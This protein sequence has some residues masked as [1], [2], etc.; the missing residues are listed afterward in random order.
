MAKIDTSDITK[1]LSHI[2][3]WSEGELAEYKLQDTSKAYLHVPIFR[4]CVDRIASSMRQIPVYTNGTR[5]YTMGERAENAWPYPTPL[6]EILY[7]ATVN[8][9]L[10]GAAYIMKVRGER[11]RRVQNLM[12]LNSTTMRVEYAGM[13]ELGN[14]IRRYIQSVNGNT[15]TFENDDIV[16]VRSYHPADDIGPG[17]PPGFTA[18]NPAQTLHYL[19]LFPAKFFEGG[20]VGKTF[21]LMP[22]GTQHK[23]TTRIQTMLNRTITGIK[24]A[25]GVEVFEGRGE[26]DIR[27]LTPAPKDLAMTEVQKIAHQQVLQAFGIPEDVFGQSQANRATAETHHRGYWNDTV[28]PIAVM[29]EDALQDGAL[30]QVNSIRFAFE[31]LPAFQADEAERANSLYVLVKAGIPL[32]TAVEALGYDLPGNPELPEYPPYMLQSQL[33]LD[34]ATE[35]QPTREAAERGSENTSTRQ[36]FN[37]NTDLRKWRRKSVKRFKSGKSAACPFESDDINEHVTAY[38]SGGL[39]RVESEEDI[40][41]LFDAAEQWSDY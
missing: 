1:M 4:A 39:T 14:P 19:T 7:K 30:D 26:I 11:F 16:F 23:E 2:P 10:F 15:Y 9:L 24:N 29:F 31:E 6:Q 35:S 41:L 22:P 28:K 25:F 34:M 12:V 20:V 17:I 5:N 40:H 27:T 18:L 13:D 8:Y 38:I 3:G 37:D 36:R 33:M 21:V 32:P